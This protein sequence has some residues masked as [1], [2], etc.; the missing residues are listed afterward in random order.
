MLIARFHF[1]VTREQAIYSDKYRIHLWV[2]TRLVDWK[3]LTGEKRE[4][5]LSTG[6]CCLCVFNVRCLFICFSPERT[7]LFV[8]SYIEFISMHSDYSESFLIVGTSDKYLI[9]YTFGLC[10]QIMNHVWHVIGRASSVRWFK[11][12]E[13]ATRI[14]KHTAWGA[15]CKSYNGRSYRV[16]QIRFVF[17][18]FTNT[19]T[20]SVT[21][22]FNSITCTML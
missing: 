13:N 9:N 10:F 16:S 20:S 14:Y 22:K 4:W 18:F 2:H 21:F 6:R 8:A 17:Y 19:L 7:V 3:Q 11:I 5:G 12:S 1:A 15:T